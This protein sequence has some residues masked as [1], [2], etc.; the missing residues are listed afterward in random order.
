MKTAKLPSKE[1]LDECLDYNPE[2]GCFTWKFRPIN[3]FVSIHG[4]KVWNAKYAGKPAGRTASTRRGKL[5]SQISINKKLIYSHRIAWVITYGDIDITMQIDHI[6]GNGSNN[7]LSNLRLV[8]A[9]TN[10]EN[11]SIP[12]NNTSG[13]V[14]VSFLTRERK[15]RARINKNGVEHTIGLFNDKSDAIKA[16]KQVEKDFGFHENHGRRKGNNGEL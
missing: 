7:R 14:G 10:N 3:H 12:S 13:C 8:D 15:W 2:T 1:Y 5:Y 16:R 6:D 4:H 9:S 11:K